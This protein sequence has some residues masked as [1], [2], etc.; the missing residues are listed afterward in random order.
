MQPKTESTEYDTINGR[1]VYN[2]KPYSCDDIL[3]EEM[4]VV[5]YADAA[6]FKIPGGPVSI[7][8]APGDVEFEGKLRDTS[9]LQEILDTLKITL[10][11]NIAVRFVFAANHNM[12]GST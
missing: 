8:I 7:T 4:E 12:V 10:R 1:L 5:F 3:E 11:E 2:G 6:R 9:K